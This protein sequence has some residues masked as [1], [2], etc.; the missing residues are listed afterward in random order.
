MSATP[1]P[2]ADPDHITIDAYRLAI[3]RQLAP[4]I[5]LSIADVYPAIIYGKRELNAD[6]SVVLVRFR[7]KVDVS[8]LAADIVAQV[9]PEHTSLPLCVGADP[10]LRSSNPTNMSPV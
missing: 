5:K 10:P 2:G 7:L 4:L 3:A 6:F 1:V 9:C 8:V